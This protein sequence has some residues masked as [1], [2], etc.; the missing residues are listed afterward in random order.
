MFL[1]DSLAHNEMLMKGAG[2]CCMYSPE[3]KVV[4]GRSHPHKRA[5]M[6]LAHPVDNGP[7][8]HSQMYSLPGKTQWGIVIKE[9]VIGAARTC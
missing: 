3:S 7:F 4:G 9:E 1:T 6:S 8:V 2:P 5:A